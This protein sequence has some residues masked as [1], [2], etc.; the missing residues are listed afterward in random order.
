M[1]TATIYRD[2][3]YEAQDRIQQLMR[4]RALMMSSLR[5]AAYS[6]ELAEYPLTAGHLR[7]TVAMIEE[8]EAK[9]LTEH[10][11]KHDKAAV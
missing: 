4:D 9:W 5:V 1:S 10:D 6:L 2:M 8:R 3:L 7:D 11:I